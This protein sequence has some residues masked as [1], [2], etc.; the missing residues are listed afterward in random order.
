MAGQLAGEDKDSDSNE[1]KAVTGNRQAMSG[2]P[3][4]A[5]H[6]RTFMC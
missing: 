4:Q 6:D 1:K 2:H 3:Q 5:G